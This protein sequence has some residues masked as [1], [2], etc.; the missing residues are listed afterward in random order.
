ML[1]SLTFS[2]DRKPSP[3]VIAIC[4][5]VIWA[6][7]RLLRVGSR[8][9][10]LPPGP[11]TVPILGNLHLIPKS[12]LGKKLREWGE[13]Y[14]GV[15]SLK[16]GNGTVIVLFDRQAINHLLDKKGVMYSERPHSFV[17]GLVTG[18]DSFA[19]MDSTP[20][21]RAERKVAVHNLSPKMLEEKVGHIQDAET[22]SSVASAV[23]FGHRG[24]TY[25]NFWAHAVYD[26]MDNYSASLE[27]GA[28]PP[29][30]EFPFL[31]YVPEFLAP[32]KKRAR[33]S[34][35]CMDDTWNEARRRVEIRRSKGIKRDSVIDSILD[36]E[37][38][39]DLQVTDKQ[40]N[41]FLGVI[42]EGGADTTASATLTSM[43]YLA[44]HPEFQVKAREQLDAVC[45]TH[46][47]PTLADFDEIP[48]INCLVKE[49]MRIHPVLPLGV[50]H[51][52]NQDDWYKGMLIPKD[53]T[54]ILPT[55]A[56]H[57][58]ESQG[59]VDPEAY[60]PDRFLGHPRM[61]D[62]Y[63]GSPDWQNRDHYGYGAGRRICPGIHLA[64]RTQWRLNARLLWAFE[65]QRK[66]D[67]KTNKPMPI[68]VDNYHEGIS[69]T[70][71]EFPVVFKPRSKAHAEL[72]K[73]EMSAAS[74]F[75][76]SWDD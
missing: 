13:K 47:L 5:L 26:A 15:Y 29:V 56:L 60:N 51:R 22:T 67:P 32:W 65:I 59:Y 4:A 1:D 3:T 34:Y 17:P 30:D 12:G 48:Y 66:I 68:D 61:A 75:L 33:G 16:F 52:V 40:M 63:A 27:P 55:W 64:E 49:A 36:G 25:D 24:R 8:D 43:M 2:A 38:H 76:R 21:W 23:V 74:D 57:L 54:V 62:S 45:G 6:L 69:H 44:L 14:K 70:P 10:R 35:R 7:Y 41:H 46:R 11:P 71:A 73:R 37:K 9:K 19:F 42:V 39:S 72:I 20:L 28:N 53:A 31:K 18:G 50:P 58:S